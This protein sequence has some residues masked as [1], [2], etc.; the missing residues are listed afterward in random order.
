[1]ERYRIVAGVGVY[2]ATFSL[3]RAQGDWW[4]SS[5]A[6]WMEGKVENDVDLAGVLW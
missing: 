3:G 2:F 1:M 6:F 4:F 5:A